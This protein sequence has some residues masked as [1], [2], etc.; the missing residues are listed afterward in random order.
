M[1]KKTRYIDA[2]R[3]I[4]GV[5]NRAEVIGDFLPPP[6]ELILRDETTKVTISLTRKS[7]EF[8]KSSAKKQGIPYQAMIRKVLD[9][10]ARRYQEK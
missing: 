8:F 3:G 5:I 2:P 1:S 10:Y 4:A 7:V 6:A 9:L